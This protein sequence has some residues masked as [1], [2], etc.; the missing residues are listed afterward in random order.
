LTPRLGGKGKTSLM[1]KPR[2]GGGERKFYR[3]HGIKVR[4]WEGTK[5]GRRPSHEKKKA[6]PSFAKR[7]E[8]LSFRL[9]TGKGREQVKK[10]GKRRKEKRPCLR[11]A[12]EKGDV[13]WSSNR[14]TED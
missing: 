12:M 14:N 3:D 10:E 6:G 8:C 4:G 5:Q 7:E 13:R 9:R 11:P 2:G 1:R